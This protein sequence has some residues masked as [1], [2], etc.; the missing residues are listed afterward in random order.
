MPTKICIIWL[1]LSL[2]AGG[3]RAQTAQDMELM[4]L[5]VPNP[6]ASLYRNQEAFA[7]AKTNS[8]ELELALSGLFLV[9]KNFVSSQD[10]NVCSFYPSCSEYGI[11]SIRAHGLVHGGV[12][13]LD[14]LMRCNGLNSQKYIYDKQRML[15]LDA[16]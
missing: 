2:S 3:L 11:L 1:F 14:R 16:P 13:T 12:A 9:Y 4:K 8:N 7:Q 6:S 10:Q 5:A 15:L